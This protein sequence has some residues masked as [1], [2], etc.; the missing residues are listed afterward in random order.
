MQQRLP[1]LKSQIPNPK[2]QITP[3]DRTLKSEDIVEVI[4]EIIRLNNDPEAKP[5]EIDHLG[6]RRVR[7]VGEVLQNRIRIGL[8][9]MERNIKD[10]MST[11]DIQTL[12][13]V[14]LIN[15]RPVM[16]V[17]KEFFTSS[18]L[19]QFMDNENPLAELEHKRRLSATGPGGLIRER[20][21]FEV[22]DVQPSHYGRVCPIQ[23]PEGPNIGL[24]NHLASFAR[25]NPYGFLETPYFK[26]EK[27]RVTSKVQYFSAFEGKNIILLTAGC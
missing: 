22:R 15:P 17:I 14:E 18:Q 6:N 26:V 24:V 3:E 4:R 25:V 7:T 13:P 5:D 8:M 10:K 11:L 16:A 19:C 23:T 27:G 1:T 20:A 12:T 21:G 9:R 2:S